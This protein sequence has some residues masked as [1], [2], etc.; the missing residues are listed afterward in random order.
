MTRETLQ[1]RTS[2]ELS[3]VLLCFPRKYQKGSQ[4][5]R[6]MA[7]LSCRSL[8]EPCMSHRL[9]NGQKQLGVSVP[10]RS[11]EEELTHENVRWRVLNEVALTQ[12]LIVF[13][14]FSIYVTCMVPGSC[15]S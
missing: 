11:A 6:S 9:K 8:P 2:S 7:K 13:D 14:R 4:I 1:V 3:V 12:L 5:E 10:P 15:G